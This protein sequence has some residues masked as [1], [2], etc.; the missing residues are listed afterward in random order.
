M[1]V[2]CGFVSNSSSTSH[3]IMWKG[4]KEDLRGL[5]EKHARK[6]ALKCRSCAAL[7]FTCNSTPEETIDLI[8]SCLDGTYLDSPLCIPTAE[9]IEMFEAEL[10]WLRKDM[11]S[12]D[13]IVM[14]SLREYEAK[15][16]H[17]VSVAGRMDWSIIVAFGDNH[18]YLHG[19]GLPCLLD[20]A[21]RNIRISSPELEYMTDQDR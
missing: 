16:L 7:G 18:G 13:D 3:I 19:R 21:G 10:K 5:L 8:C 4:K 9:R 11:E 2:R 20:Y 17:C 6:F 1:K 15:V 12:A 14:R